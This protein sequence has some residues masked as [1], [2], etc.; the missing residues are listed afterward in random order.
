MKN[1]FPVKGHMEIQTTILCLGKG[2]RYSAAL[3]YRSV[4]RYIQFTQKRVF[5]MI[6]GNFLLMINLTSQNIPLLYGMNKIGKP[7][8][9][10]GLQ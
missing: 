10:D 4:F 3:T 1:P 9:I 8:H 2:R 5:S 6:L 7:T